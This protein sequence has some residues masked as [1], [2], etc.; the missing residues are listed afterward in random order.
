MPKQ[1]FQTMNGLRG[2]AA[3]A[4]LMFHAPDWFG[5][6]APA[7]GF[8]AVDLFFVLSGFV[9][10]H[11]YELRLQLDM[12]VRQFFIVRWIRLYPLYVIGVAIGVI[13]PFASLIF[14]RHV[15]NQELDAFNSI[16]FS[17]AMIP[18]I[19]FSD[20]SSS[21]YPNNPPAWSLL[22]EL[23][24]NFIYAFSW[25]YWSTRNIL[26]TM[27]AIGCVMLAMP[28][29]YGDGGYNLRSTG[30]GLL[31]VFYSFPA[32]VLIFRLV[33]G[34]KLRLPALNSVVLLAAFPLLLLLPSGWV[35]QFCVL[36][37]FPVLVAFAARSEPA[38]AFAP[39]F[40]WL[41]GI[42]Y[43]VYAIHMPLMNVA[44]AILLK[45]G[46]VINPHLAAIVF[47]VAVVAVSVALDK[48]FDTP[49][50]RHLTRRLVGPKSKVAVALR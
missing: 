42:S 11:S 31:R 12:T 24:A 50:R 22:F 5:V 9:I 39:M 27:T 26:M 16:P 40:A 45:L 4:V 46:L 17:I 14:H 34:N 29:F 25:R 1:V 44:N 8:L 15:I 10:A 47:L 2:I 20:V 28:D 33:S 41:G 36:L 21:F 35:V 30:F 23:I 13:V 38:G 37:G 6:M 7:K 3:L 32:G 48:G 19:N 43:A 18:F 49:I